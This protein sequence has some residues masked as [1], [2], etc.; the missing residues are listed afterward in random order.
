[1]IVVDTSV[2]INFFRGAETSGSR[3]LAELDQD[4]IPFVIPGVCC[5]ELLQGSKDAREWSLLSAYLGSQR[6]LHPRD[7]W[8]THI[9]AARIY[10]ELRR[11]GVTVRSTVD[12]WIAQSVL[13]IDGT[14]L[15]EDGDFD[16]VRQIRE[17]RTIP[18]PQ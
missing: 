7:P 18:E 17:L 5:Q 16:H 3:W 13:E 14:L 15:H 12:C 10:F 11:R 4:D 2:L 8:Q 6:I 9:E 1:M